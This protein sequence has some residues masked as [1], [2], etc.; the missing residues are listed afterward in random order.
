MERRFDASETIERQALEDLHAALPSPLAKALGVRR[1]QVGG[2]LVSLSSIEPSILINRTIGL[3][4][5]RA[6]TPAEIATIHTA[7]ADAGVDEY[8]VHLTEGAGHPAV[9]AMLRAAGWVPDRGWMKFVR[10]NEPAPTPDSDLSV[11]AIS[12]EHAADF[13]RIVAHGF[14]LVQRTQDW[15][16]CLV[17]RPNWHVYIS[18]DGDR[19]VGTGA[20]FVSNGIGYFDFGATDPE[21]RG[22]GGQSA[23]LAHRIGEARR[24][25]C[26]TLVTATGEAVPG[27]PQHSYHNIMRAGFKETYLRRNWVLDRAERCAAG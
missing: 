25:G 1:V 3:G 15:L 2:A 6:P 10:A 11:R 7:Y 14:D 22:R 16:G 13:A 5:D 8:F 4:V 26:T 19:P 21:F 18:F 27:D 24:L 17:G 23:L 9:V 20:L 12:G